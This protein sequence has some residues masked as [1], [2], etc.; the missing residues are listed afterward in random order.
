[1]KNFDFME[2]LEEEQNDIENNENSNSLFQRAS[3]IDKKQQRDNHSSSLNLDELQ[4]ERGLFT[5]GKNKKI[6]M[7]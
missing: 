2:E 7:P 3:K 4:E 1:M 6:E 5:N